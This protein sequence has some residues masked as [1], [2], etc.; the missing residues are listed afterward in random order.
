MRHV[1]HYL[2]GYPDCEKMSTTLNIARLH[3]FFFTR[4]QGLLFVNEILN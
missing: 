3:W 2:K 1:Q 4:I